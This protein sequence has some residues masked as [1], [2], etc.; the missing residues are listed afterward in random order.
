MGFSAIVNK[1]VKRDADN[2]SEKERKKERREEER[3]EGE[4]PTILK[5]KLVAGWLRVEGQIRF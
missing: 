2:N 4:N 3:R 5:E 1:P